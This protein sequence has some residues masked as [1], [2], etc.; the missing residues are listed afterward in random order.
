[1]RDYVA[2]TSQSWKEVEV[3][4]RKDGGKECTGARTTVPQRWEAFHYSLDLIIPRASRIP[5]EPGK[6]LTSN[7]RKGQN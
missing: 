1:M 5:G 3:S 2:L 4:K 7:K 6:E